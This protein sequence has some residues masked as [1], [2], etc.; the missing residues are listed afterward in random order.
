M[1]ALDR[2]KLARRRDAWRRWRATGELPEMP[3]AE[4]AAEARRQRRTFWW[5]DAWEEDEGRPP[6]ERTR[7]PLGGGPFNGAWRGSLIQ[8]ITTQPTLG[9]MVAAAA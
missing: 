8:S 2:E 5:V 9:A 3:P 4:R 6:P 1:D 7:S